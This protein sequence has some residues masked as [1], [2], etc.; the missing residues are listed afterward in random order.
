MSRTLKIPILD[1]YTHLNTN[2]IK[3]RENF[4]E[5]REGY[6]TTRWM[7]PGSRP[8]GPGRPLSGAA[9]Q[10]QRQPTR[11]GGGVGLMLVVVRS[12]FGGD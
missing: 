4:K 6:A 2:I 8:S 11:G 5:R 3:R 9:G 12:D 1:A 7:W 10:G